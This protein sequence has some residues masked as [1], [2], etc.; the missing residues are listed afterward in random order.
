MRKKVVVATRCQVVDVQSP[1]SSRARMKH[2]KEPK[3][4]KQAQQHSSL[5]W[6]CDET[7]FRFARSRGS[8]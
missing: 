3:L 8:V 4:R 5:P 6:R 1:G 7:P 2:P